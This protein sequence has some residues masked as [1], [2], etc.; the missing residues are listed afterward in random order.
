MAYTPTTAFGAELL[1]RLR[2]WA[3][4]DLAIYADAF[5]AM[6]DEVYTL[7]T[8]QGVDGDPDYVPGYGILFDVDLC[9]AKWLGYLAQLVGVTIPA[10]TAEA[11]ARALIR[12]HAGMNRGTAESIRLAV[13]ATLTAPQT[14]TIDERVDGDA[15]AILIHTYTAQTPDPGATLA[16]ALSQKPGG[17]ILTHRIDPDWDYGQAEALFATYGLAEAQYATYGA[18][19]SVIPPGP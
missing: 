5:G 18:A 17:L 19:E 3:T 7:V 12:A 1:E 8:D 4:D 10:G 2:P 14:V 6:A 13:Q 9:P 16:A 15:Y 11:D